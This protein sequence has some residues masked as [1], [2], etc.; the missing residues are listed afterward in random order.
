MV[1]EAMQIDAEKIE[2]TVEG[3]MDLAGTLGVSQ[4]VPVGFE[5][6]RTT[7][8]IVAPDASDEQLE[9]LRKSTEQYCVVYQTL[10]NTPELQTE[11]A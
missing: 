10:A 4:D 6:I 5:T 9:K 2:V 7:F 3:D 1:A 11:W 8:D